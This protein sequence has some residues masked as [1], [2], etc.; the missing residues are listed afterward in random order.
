MGRSETIF[1][2][3]CFANVGHS[4]K[5][6]LSAR[7]QNVFSCASPQHYALTNMYHADSLTPLP[8]LLLQPFRRTTH[9]HRQLPSS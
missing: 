2:G 4:S 1:P 8:E 7:K 6:D 3:R 9:Y 5:V